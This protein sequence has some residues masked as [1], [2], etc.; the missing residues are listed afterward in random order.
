M[1]GFISSEEAALLVAAYIDDDSNRTVSK[2]DLPRKHQFVKSHHRPWPV[3]DLPGSKGD[4]ST[5]VWSFQDDNLALHLTR[6]A[7][8]RGSAWERQ[9]LLSMKD[10]G[11]RLFRD[12]MTTM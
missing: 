12:D 11:H 3:E 2:V 5:G 1:W 7:L 6:N 9:R 8:G 4:K 10:N